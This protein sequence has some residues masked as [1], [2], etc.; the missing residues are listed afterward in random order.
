MRSIC[1]AFGLAAICAVGLGAQSATTKSK[2][3]VEVKDGKEITVGGCLER[4]PG[5]GYMLTSTAGSMKYA[6]ITDDDL[7]KHVG[8]RVEV[9]GKAA[10]RGDGKVKIE[11]TVGSG[12]DKS[13][14]KTEIKGNDMSGMHYLGMKS[15]KMISASCV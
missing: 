2:T 13:K 9:K 10:D 3:K 6:L 15:L 8:H 11:S 7:S 1:A 14:A 4:N 5:G 12:D